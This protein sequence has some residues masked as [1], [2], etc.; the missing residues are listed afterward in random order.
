MRLSASQGSGTSSP[1]GLKVARGVV[2]DWHPDRT[3]TRLEASHDGYMRLAQRVTHRRTIHV[4]H[5]AGL[6]SVDDQLS[7]EG[8]CRAEAFLHLAPGVSVD[9]RSET[10]LELASTGGDHATLAWQGPPPGPGVGT[11][12]VSPSY[13]VYEDAP[14]VVATVSGQ[15]PL[16]FGWRISLSDKR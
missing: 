11:G 4:D 8:T 10:H 9:S 12:R 13:G 16:R 3:K 5:G 1:A 2:C 15:L 7:G 6:V 14:V